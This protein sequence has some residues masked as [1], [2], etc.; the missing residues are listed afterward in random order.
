M[1]LKFTTEHGFHWG[2]KN[3]LCLKIWNRNKNVI[4]NT[5]LAFIWASETGT[6][7]ALN[8]GGMKDIDEKY[9]VLNQGRNNFF[10]C[11][12]QKRDLKNNKKKFFKI[13]ES[14]RRSRI[15]KNLKWWAWAGGKQF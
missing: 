14:W 2:I 10:F 12:E 6:L 7:T 5:V 4:I 9:L 3:L 13:K 1:I 15:L 11:L 8:L